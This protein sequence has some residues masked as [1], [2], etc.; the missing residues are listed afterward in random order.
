MIAPAG[1]SRTWSSKLTTCFTVLVALLDLAQ[2]VLRAWRPKYWGALAGAVLYAGLS[3]AI[4]YRRSR[5]A[6]W[7]VVLMPVVPIVTLLATAFGLSFPVDRAMI[8]I[9][10]CQLLAAASAGCECG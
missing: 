8:A 6:L 10:F 9:A 2:P 3:W 7:V 4:A 1:S 5:A